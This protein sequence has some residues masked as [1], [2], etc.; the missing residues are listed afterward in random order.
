MLTIFTCRDFQPSGS[1][2]FSPTTIRPGAQNG[3][4]VDLDRSAPAG[5]RHRKGQN[6]NKMSCFEDTGTENYFNEALSFASL[7]DQIPGRRLPGAAAWEP[8]T[9]PISGKLNKSS[10]RTVASFGKVGKSTLYL[11]GVVIHARH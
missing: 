11:A 3:S 4:L 9:T 2:E 6:A 8:G 5:D 10:F 1:G 7:S